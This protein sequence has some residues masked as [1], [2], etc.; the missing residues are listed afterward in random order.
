MYTFLKMNDASQKSSPVEVSSLLNRV[1]DQMLEGFQVIDKNWTYLYVNQTVANQGKKKPEELIGH[2]MMECYPGIDKT[3][4][5]GYL[6]NCMQNNVSKT[7]E[8]E[9]AYPDNSRGWF[10]LY[11][12]PIEDGILILS[13]DITAHKKAEQELYIKIQELETLQDTVI[14][15]E[16]KMV[17][18][19]RTIATLQQITP[20]VPLPMDAQATD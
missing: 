15:R 10:R 5:F 18:L 9:F 7:I 16:L 14:D 3:P 20:S 13:L 1:V 4:L 6:T 19:K 2:T 17:E 12:H 8:N 11:I